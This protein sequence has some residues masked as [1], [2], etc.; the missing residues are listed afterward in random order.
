MSA[1]TEKFQFQTESRQLLD[2]MVHSIYT[3]KEIFLRELISNASDA[4]D[5]L[6]IEVLSNPGLIAPGEKLEIRLEADKDAKTLTITDNGIGMSHDDLIQHIGTIAKSGTKEF[7]EKI[8][9]GKS[10]ED[11]SEMIGQFGVG[12]YSSFMAADRVTILTRKA[13]TTSAYLWSSYGDGEFTITEAEKPSQGSVITLYLKPADPDNGLEDFTDPY[14]IARVVKHYSDFINYPIIAKDEREEIEK[15][16]DG[17]PKKDGKKTRIIEDKTLNSMK[18]IWTKPQADVTEEEYHDFYKHISHDWNEPLKTIN[19]RAEGTMEFYSLLFIPSHAPFDL[20]YQGYKSGLQL[21]VKKVLIQEAFEDLLP[22]YLRFMKGVVESSDLPLNISRELLQKD[23]HITQMKKSLTKKA[24]D[25]LQEL[26]DKDALNY[27]KF[28]KEFGDA[29]KEGV[30]SDFENRDKLTGLLLFDSSNDPEKL[31]SLDEYIERMKEGQNE[32]YYITGESRHILENSPHLEK[33]KEKGY[34]VLFLLKPIDEILSQYLNEFKGKKLKSAN[35][36]DLDIASKDEKKKIEEEMKGKT[37]EFSGLLQ[38]IQS[39][40]EQNIKEVRLSSRL[41]SAPAC[42]VGGEYDI[43]PHL[44]KL[45]QKENA[46]KT[47]PKRIL[48]VNPN[49]PI[50]VKMKDKFAQNKDDTRLADYSELL[51]GYAVLSEEGALPNPV[52]F[53]KLVVDLMD[54]SLSN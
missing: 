27:L 44:E 26:Y 9:G 36:G 35:K 38:L 53:N 41:V 22:K 54:I 4:L 19:Y 5:K 40:L 15:D 33:L 16:A 23:R 25:S 14:T 18:P 32:I 29:L 50:L 51:L 7:M 39:K 45:L 30:I 48:E 10:K 17:K 8:K 47:P 46:G 31:T 37:D 24:L 21:Y 43:S 12:F 34:E 42:L 11:L 52:R 28:W 2:L 6:R 20:F 13:G 3:N 49:H 1:T